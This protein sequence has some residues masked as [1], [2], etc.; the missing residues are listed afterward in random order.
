MLRA[1]LAIG[2]LLA[3]SPLAH[4]ASDSP[5]A[6]QFAAWL[7]AFNNGDRTGLL[8]YHQRAFPYE[9]ASRDVGDIDREFGLSQGTGG[10]ELL[11]AE[12]VT[13]T[14]FTATGD[15]LG[16]PLG[17]KL[18]GLAGN[19]P[20]PRVSKRST[21]AAPHNHATRRPLLRTALRAARVRVRARVRARPPT[22]R[23]SRRP[24]RSRAA[25]PSATRRRRGRAAER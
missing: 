12:E 14:S 9:V 3:T 2:L 15:P 22:A 25:P 7:E 11:K 8:A 5:A 1:I 16:D 19:A 13:A 20:P 6:K 4:A 21:L 24:R 18:A 17:A 23:T 10:F